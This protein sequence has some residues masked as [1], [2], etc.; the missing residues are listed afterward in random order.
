MLTS[1]VMGFFPFADSSKVCLPGSIGFGSLPVNELAAI[2]AAPS[3][4]IRAP[5]TGA[6]S[7]TFSRWTIGKTRSY[8]AFAIFALSVRGGLASIDRR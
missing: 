6:A 1:F 8:S 7:V 3:S 5:S 4:E 2:F